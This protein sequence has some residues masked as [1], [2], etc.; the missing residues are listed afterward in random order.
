MR[1]LLLALSLLAGC[2]LSLPSPPPPITTTK[3][4]PPGTFNPTT[5]FELAANFEAWAPNDPERQ[6]KD[7]NAFEHGISKVENREHRQWFITN[8]RLANRNAPP[9][10]ALRVTAHEPNLRAAFAGTS[11][12]VQIVRGNDVVEQLEVNASV[13]KGS[14]TEG[15]LATELGEM[16][17]RYVVCRSGERPQPCR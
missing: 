13:S 4:A 7:R 10:F 12:T 8:P 9:G 11:A 14:D 2:G 17:A 5:T 15:S 6:A 3:E 16:I 1:P